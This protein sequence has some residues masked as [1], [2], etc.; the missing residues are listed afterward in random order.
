ML[1]SGGLKNYWLTSIEMAFTYTYISALVFGCL[2]S[3]LWRWAFS[4]CG[5]KSSLAVVHGLQSPW[6][7]QL[8]RVGLVAPL[9]PGIEQAPTALDGRFLTTGQSGKSPRTG[10]SHR[11]HSLICLTYDWGRRSSNTLT[12]GFL[13]RVSI[14]GY[15]IWEALLLFL[16]DRVNAHLLCILRA[17][18]PYWI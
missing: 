11:W 10:Y 3:S 14:V 16:S 18:T 1:N 17:Q 15:V 5:S 2:G 7:Q 13:H 6:V 9:W 4:S 8:W 12:S